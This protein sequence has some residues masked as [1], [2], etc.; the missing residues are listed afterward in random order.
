MST[1]DTV[2]LL[3]GGAASSQPLAGR[4]IDLFAAG[5]KEVCTDLARAI[6]SDGEGATHLITVD[7]VG[8][9][10]RDDAFRIAKTVAD[11]PLVKTAVAGGDPN[12]G[13]IVSAAGYAG[14]SFDPSQVALSLNGIPLYGDGAPVAFDAATAAASIRANHE[15]PV[16]LTF[17]EGDARVRFYTSDLTAEYIRINADY[18][19]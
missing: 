3:A 10:S 12:W 19:T 8:C 9:A 11:S 7:V 1:N 15:T 6:P 5:L 2:L 17:A 13:R 18:H 16:E 14:V 4:D